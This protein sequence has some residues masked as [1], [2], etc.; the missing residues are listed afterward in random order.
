[1]SIV[2]AYK[3]MG[4][5]G[6]SYFLFSMVWVVVYFIASGAAWY[7]GFGFVLLSVEWV[8][9][10]GLLV[11]LASLLVTILWLRVW[12]GMTINKISRRDYAR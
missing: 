5:S 6:R 9:R 11:P 8:E 3:E 12:G 10:F 2:F 4:G 1:M 7:G